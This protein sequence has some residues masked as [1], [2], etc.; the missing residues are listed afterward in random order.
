M[1]ASP[2][3]LQPV[4]RP[5]LEEEFACI[6]YAS[7]TPLGWS[8][9]HDP[10]THEGPHYDGARHDDRGRDLQWHLVSTSPGS[11]E[12]GWGGMRHLSE[13]QHTELR[14]NIRSQDDCVSPSYLL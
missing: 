3:T 5:L 9:N 13:R 1:G 14:S 6:R 8:H 11:R 7:T 4:C 2:V 12:L 10:T